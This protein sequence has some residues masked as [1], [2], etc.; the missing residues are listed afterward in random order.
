MKDYRYGLGAE[1][2]W[3]QT[4][5]YGTMLAEPIVH[6][7]QVTGGGEHFAYTT[8]DYSRRADREARFDFE[9]R[10]SPTREEALEQAERRLRYIR[11]EAQ[12]TEAAAQVALE[13]LGRLVAS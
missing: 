10:V 3:V 5:T 9:R 6:R 2:W 12:K 8:W 7:G 1:V 4:H 11:D 13:A